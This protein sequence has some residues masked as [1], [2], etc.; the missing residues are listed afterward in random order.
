MSISNVWFASDLH[1]GHSAIAKHRGFSSVEEHDSAILHN[2]QCIKRKDK[3]FLL[4]DVVW[5]DKSLK[6]LDEIPGI[7]ELIIGNHDRLQT[8][9]YLKYFVKVHGFRK[10]QDLWLSHCP[11]HPQEVYWCKGNVHGHIHKGAGTEDL[12]GSYF[13]VNVDFNKMSPTNFLTIQKY[14]E[15][16][17]V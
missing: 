15:E 3:L 5:N 14:Y 4:G 6:L 12:G 10:Y 1:L 17:Y 2:F 16:R 7:K 9:K 11:I 13:N 8:K